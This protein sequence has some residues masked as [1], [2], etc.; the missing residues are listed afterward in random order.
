[1]S[2]KVKWDVDDYKNIW[3]L[4]TE[5]IKR[6]YVVNYLMKKDYQLPNY[7]PPS[8]HSRRL[9]TLEIIKQSGFDT[10]HIWKDKKGYC[11]EK[12][13]TCLI[14]S[15]SEKLLTEEEHEWGMKRITMKGGIF[16]PVEVQ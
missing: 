2:I 12:S 5:N 9:R 6:G 16:V 4:Y 15:V 13:F 1:M 11:E 8:K 3:D 14:K 7:V 10:H